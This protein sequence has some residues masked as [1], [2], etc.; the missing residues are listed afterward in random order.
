[1][2]GK[3][4][5]QVKKN[6]QTKLPSLLINIKFDYKYTVDQD[7][8]KNSDGTS[9]PN[10]PRPFYFTQVFFKE[11][12]LNFETFINKNVLTFDCIPIMDHCFFKHD[13]VVVDI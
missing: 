13:M 3:R 10:K 11:D 12:R 9:W 8:I 7:E 2:E 5:K 4:A 1:M 6:K